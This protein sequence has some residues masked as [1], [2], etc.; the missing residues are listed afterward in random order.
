MC[1][2]F[3]SVVACVRISFPLFDWIIVHHMCISHSIY[4]SIQPLMDT[5]LVSMFS[6]LE[7]SFNEH[8]YTNISLRHYPEVELLHAN[9][10][11]NFLRITILFSTV[12]VPFYISTEEFPFFGKCPMCT[13]EECIFCCRVYWTCLLDLVD[14]LCCSS[15]IFPSWSFVCCPIHYCKS[16]TEFSNYYCRT[17]YFFFQFW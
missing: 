14:L 15:F 17:V 16:G 4:A 3:I 5:W 6:L 9:S 8:G 1:S 11:F 10:I 7:K 2:R 13:Q 12:A